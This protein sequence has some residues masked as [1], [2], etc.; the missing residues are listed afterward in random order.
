MPGMST[1]LSLPP[2]SERGFAFVDADTMRA[3][4]AHT[5]DLSDFDT[6]ADSWNRLELDTYMADHGRYRR[7]RHGVFR[8]DRAHGM[9][10]QPRQPHYQ[11]L[12]Y[13]RLNGGVER[14]YQ[15]LEPAATDSAT[16][17]TVLGY[18]WSLFG[19]LAPQVAAWHVEVHQF[20]IEA[21]PDEEGRPTPEGMHRDGVDYV[22]VMLVARHNIDCGTTRIHA[23]DG[24]ELGSFTLTR[25]FDVSLVDDA[26][27]FHGV[28]PVQAHDPAAP[29]WRDVLVVTF[30]RA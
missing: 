27:V 30:R 2:L 22:L 15:P 28:T 10:P 3:L 18:A 8:A 12:D 7:R 23:P 13:N 20:R 25:P 1:A 19:T 9:Q 24:R 16:L 5:G 26:R 29:G 6:F 4:L 21:R 11:S 17:G 14:W